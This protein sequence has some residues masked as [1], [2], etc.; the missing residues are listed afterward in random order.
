MG[1]YRAQFGLTSAESTLQRADTLI[2][3]VEKDPGMADPLLGSA[4][5]LI[6]TAIDQ[7]VNH[8]LKS[9][10]HQLDPF[11]ENESTNPALEL[12]D[13]G[14]WTRIRRSPEVSTVA[15]FVLDARGD[16]GT[17]LREL[18]DRRNDLVH[19]DEDVVEFD[20]MVN[21]AS[22]DDVEGAR[23]ALLKA[24]EDGA[25]E[26]I[27][28]NQPWAEVT[29]AEARRSLAAAR[30]YFKALIEEDNDA[31]RQLARRR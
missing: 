19:I 12:L 7:L 8:W 6:A 5:V 26:S 30:L 24:I 22:E 11:H 27:R 2:T 28:L 13:K 14:L 20:V 15:P 3:L 18:V 4:I 1:L 10:A 16:Y 17:Y 23:D 9:A 29:I 25:L 31:I 21:D